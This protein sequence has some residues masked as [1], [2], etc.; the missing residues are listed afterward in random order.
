MHSAS[1]L[2]PA[3]LLSLPLALLAGAAQAQGAPAWKAAW[4]KSINVPYNGKWTNE[5]MPAFKYWWGF[6]ITEVADDGSIKGLYRRVTP[7]G[8]HCA[9]GM[10][11]DVAKEVPMQGKISEDGKK[12][13]LALAEAS[14]ELLTTSA[15]CKPT[16]FDLEVKESDKDG[17]PLNFTGRGKSNFNLGVAYTVKNLEWATP[18]E[19]REPGRR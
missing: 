17:S 9:T 10:R 3:L 11:P 15:G 18:D 13:H 19:K 6:K 1:K 8:G 4:D 5:D 16:F 7:D 12:L 14:Y 2:L